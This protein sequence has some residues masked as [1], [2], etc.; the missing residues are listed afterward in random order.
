[1]WLSQSTINLLLSIPLTVGVLVTI[2]DTL[3]FL[4]IDKYGVRKLEF[5]FAILIA[6]MAVSFG[7]E[8]TVHP[9]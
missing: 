8:V 3:S 7:F 4:F 9:L 5:F 6:T 2:L 1:M